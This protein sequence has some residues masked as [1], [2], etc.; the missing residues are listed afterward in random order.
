MT[1]TTIEISANSHDVLLKLA[2]EEGL[3]MQTLLDKAIEHYRRQTFMKKVNEAYAT[4]RQDP[5]AW[6]GIREEREAWDTTLDDGLQ[7]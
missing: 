2:T 1:T 5:T 7:L 6:K 4:L 3:S